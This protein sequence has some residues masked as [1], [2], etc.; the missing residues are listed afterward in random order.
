VK[1]PKGLQS[2]LRGEM[3]RSNRF[4][5]SCGVVSFFPYSGGVGLLASTTGSV[6]FPASG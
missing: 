5:N 4:F 1:T 6:I 3:G 2:F